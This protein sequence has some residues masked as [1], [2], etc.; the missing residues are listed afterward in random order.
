MPKIM[1]EVIRVSKSVNIK[2]NPWKITRINNPNPQWNDNIYS[3]PS[4]QSDFHTVRPGCERF[5][6]WCAADAGSERPVSTSPASSLQSLAAVF[7]K[8]STC[9][10]SRTSVVPARYINVLLVRWRYTQ[11]PQSPRQ[12]IGALRFDAVDHRIM[13]HHPLPW[14]HPVPCRENVAFVRRNEVAL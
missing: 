8:I 6:S 10:I 9:L 14:R 1:N 12:P 5:P 13:P 4:P 3:L 7:L 2:K 11:R